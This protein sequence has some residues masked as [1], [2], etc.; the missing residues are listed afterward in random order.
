[1]AGS[2]NTLAP[3]GAS[4]ITDTGEGKKG[5]ISFLGLSVPY[6]MWKLKISILFKSVWL[7]VF[8][9]S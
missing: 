3:K 2:L 6:L 5:K 7:F 8:W 1:M 9:K 4:S